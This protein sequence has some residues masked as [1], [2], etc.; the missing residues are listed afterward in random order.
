MKTLASLLITS[1]A[2]TLPIVSAAEKGDDLHRRCDEQERQ[3][4]RLELENSR[5]R[6]L[7]ADHREA[8]V[9]PV[10]KKEAAAPATTAPQPEAAAKPV[11]HT[12]KAGESLS[13]I[14]TR[15]GTTTTKLVKLN[16]LRNAGL[17]RVGQRLQITEAPAS[18]SPAASPAT[19]TAVATHKVG[20]GETFY[21]IARRHGISVDDLARANPDVNANALRIGQTLKL[22]SPTP[23][24]EP[25]R[26]VASSEP[27]VTKEAPAPRKK[28]AEAT[29]TVSQRTRVTSVRIT[30]KIKFADFAAQYDASPAK[31]NALN[32]L[33]LE[34]NQVLAEGSEL[35][36]PAQPH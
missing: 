8:A 1:C 31:L 22:A 5:L 13:K 7:L 18:Q 21:S 24:A 32:G 16:G 35:Y 20:A 33:S 34:P 10:F 14:A 25:K 19:Q 6:E 23:A 17:I 12:V 15:H 26:E 28:E 29:E 30:E 3:I 27:K 2:L 9:A 4:R 36:I 11:Y